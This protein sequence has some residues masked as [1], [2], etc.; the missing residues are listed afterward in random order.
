MI[1]IWPTNCCW[2]KV[3]VRNYKQCPWDIVQTV[4]IPFGWLVKLFHANLL[5]L[6]PLVP[7]LEWLVVGY[8]QPRSQTSPVFL[9]FGMHI[10]HGNGRVAK[11]GS[12]GNTYH[13]ND[14]RWTWGGCRGRGVPCSHSNNILVFI[15]KHS[16]AR[17]TPGVSKITPLDR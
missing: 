10:I 2:V 7:V 6:F 5:S 3:V 17:Q 4:T 1:C 16:I 14:V 13:T 9:F 11:L 12:S 8:I 15:I